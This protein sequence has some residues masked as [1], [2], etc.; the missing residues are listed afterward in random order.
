[1]VDICKVLEE[2]LALRD[3]DLKVNNIKVER[4]IEAAIPAVTADPHQ[5]EQV[6]LNIINNGVDAMLELGRAGSL[7]V[8]IYTQDE[9]VIAE[10]R[11]TGPGIK[12]PN[13]IFDPFYT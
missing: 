2:T 11:D 4:D 6:F 1:Q 13:R 8:R 10:F 9:D 7:K 3:Y 12:E 5:L